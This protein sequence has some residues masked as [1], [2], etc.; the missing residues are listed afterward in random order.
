MVVIRAGT[1]SKPT[2]DRLGVGDNSPVNVGKAQ[3]QKSAVRTKNF[4]LPNNSM[5]YGLLTSFGLKLIHIRDP[6]QD[7]KRNSCIP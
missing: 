5:L 6:D 1:L 7:I 3:V 4:S 2:S